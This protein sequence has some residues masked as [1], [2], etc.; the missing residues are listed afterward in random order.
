MIQKNSTFSVLSSALTSFEN[1]PHDCSFYEFDTCQNLNFSE[2]FYVNHEISLEIVNTNTFNPYTLPHKNQSFF[3]MIY[4]YC[5]NT[6]ICDMQN[7][8]DFSSPIVL[9]HYT[10][11]Y[12][13]FTNLT[14]ILFTKIK[15]LNVQRIKNN[16]YTPKQMS[17]L[18]YIISS[19]TSPGRGSEYIMD[20]T[21]ELIDNEFQDEV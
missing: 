10:D 20:M 11:L 21:V 9:I 8:K 19:F 16:V 12:H 13:K 17:Q 18:L 2:M 14:Q 1:M 3:K 5:D 15:M 4:T 7:Y 6:Y